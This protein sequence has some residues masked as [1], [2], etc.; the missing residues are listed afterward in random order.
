MY[1][2][3]L[4]Q[5]YSDACTHESKQDA[6]SLLAREIAKAQC[7]FTPN[8]W[9]DNIHMQKKIAYILQKYPEVKTA[10]EENSMTA[11]YLSN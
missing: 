9:T 3:Q 10:I 8:F 4:I 6:L 7:T 2:D 5:N 11:E 1:R